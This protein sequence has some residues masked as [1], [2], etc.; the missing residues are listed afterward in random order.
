MPYPIYSQRASALLAQ[1]RAAFPSERVERHVDTLEFGGFYI[2]VGENQDC[3]RA[4][5]RDPHD[6]ALAQGAER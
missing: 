6:L 4:I 5:I 3:P 1:T 2:A